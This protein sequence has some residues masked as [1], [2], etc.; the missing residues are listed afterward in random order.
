MKSTALILTQ[1][2][3]ANSSNHDALDM[4]MVLGTFEIPTALFFVSGAVSQF[5][6]LNPEVL[7]IKNYVKSFAALPFYDV[8]DLYVC[9][10][11]FQSH[12]M[13]TE[14][15]PDD[16]Q[17]LNKQEIREKLQCYHQVIKF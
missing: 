8:E 3:F 4:A 14:N 11:D 13:S 7:G 5:M 9:R 15:L 1:S 16:F 12:N 6:T 17:L 2:P 10:E